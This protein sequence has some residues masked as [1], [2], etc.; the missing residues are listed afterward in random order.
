MEDMHRTA[1][2]A[3]IGNISMKLKRKLQ[4]DPS[5]EEFV[6]DAEANLMRVREEREPWTLKNILG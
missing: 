1:T 2:I 6:N 3:H 5:K 4:W